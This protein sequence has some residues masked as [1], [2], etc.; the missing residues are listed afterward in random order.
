MVD[1]GSSP[2]EGAEVVRRL[3]PV[4]RVVRVALLITVSVGIVAGTWQ[5]NDQG[6][7]FAPMSQFAFAISSSD[8][9]IHS[10]Y[11]EATTVDGER[12]RLDLS[13]GALGLQRAEIEGQLWSFTQDPALLQ[14]IAVLHSRRA[15]EAPRLTRVDVMDD[16]RLVRGGVAGEARTVTVVSWPVIDPTSPR[17]LT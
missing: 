11:L 17:E 15:P 5:R 9:E 1:R 12:V 16:V 6:W 7:P 8:G 4:G 10:R 14:A 2:A 13:R 3:A